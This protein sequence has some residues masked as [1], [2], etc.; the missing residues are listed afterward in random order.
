MMRMRI[1]GSPDFQ[2]LVEDIAAWQERNFGPPD[3]E[4]SYLGLV[5]EVGEVMRAVV[6][7]RQGIREEWREEWREEI[8]KEIGDVSIRLVDVARCESINLANAIDDR[9]DTIQRRNWK[10]DPQGHGIDGED[11][12]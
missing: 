12:P 11:L 10:T 6:K 5:E 4:V 1:S 7:R 2:M 8:R 9:W 3:E